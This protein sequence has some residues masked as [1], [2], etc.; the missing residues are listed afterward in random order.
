MSL[1]ATKQC[2]HDSS[3]YVKAFPDCIFRHPL[4]CGSDNVKCI[5]STLLGSLRGC[6]MPSVP[7]HQLKL[8]Q[9]QSR[10]GT[11]RTFFSHYTTSNDIQWKWK[12]KLIKF[13]WTNTW[14]WL[15]LFP[16]CHMVMYLK[17]HNHDLSVHKASDRIIRCC[18]PHTSLRIL[19]WNRCSIDCKS[20]QLRTHRS[21]KISHF[22]LKPF[23]TIV[24]PNSMFPFWR[25]MT[26][27]F[28]FWKWVGLREVLAGS[29]PRQMEATSL[30]RRFDERWQPSVNPG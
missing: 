2:S 3:S 14:P 25:P 17:L 6:K 26:C 16:L 27:V 22:N 19:D 23:R 8:G 7:S 20:Q 15:L 30:C 10:C 4:G 9:R 18:N 1:S 28:P 12:K 13:K 29:V 11:A 21:L 24:P 5:R